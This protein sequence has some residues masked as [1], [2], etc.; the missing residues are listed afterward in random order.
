MDRKILPKPRHCKTNF[1][2]AISISFTW[3]NP[4]IQQGKRRNNIASTIA[5]ARGFSQ[6]A[7]NY[8]SVLLTVICMPARQQGK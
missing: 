3:L 5:A 4:L 1:R 8:I 7:G 6:L 2:R